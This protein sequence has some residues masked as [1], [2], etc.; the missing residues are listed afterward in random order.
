[1]RVYLFQMMWYEMWSRSL[2]TEAFK[3]FYIQIQ[4]FCEKVCTV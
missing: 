1:M 3:F 2:E 4:N